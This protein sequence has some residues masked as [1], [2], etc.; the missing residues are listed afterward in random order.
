MLK[1][2]NIYSVCTHLCTVSLI[3]TNFCTIKQ[4]QSSI[5][6]MKVVGTDNCKRTDG[7]NDRVGVEWSI[8]VWSI[9]HNFVGL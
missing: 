2:R 3:T 6:D 9:C 8:Q 5:L 4:T 1:A 7:E